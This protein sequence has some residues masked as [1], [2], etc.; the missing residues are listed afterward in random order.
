[1][2]AFPQVKLTAGSKWKLGFT[3]RGGKFQFQAD[4]DRMELRR[5]GE[6][7]EPILPGRIKEVVNVTG[8]SASLQDVVY[9]GLYEYPPEAFR[10]GAELVLRV[11]EQGVAEPQVLPLSDGLVT[12]IR[13]DYRDYFAANSASAP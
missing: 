13:A 4:F 3:G 10:E 7:V 11:W 2:R 5:G 12:K 1:M 9:W 6:L 8:P